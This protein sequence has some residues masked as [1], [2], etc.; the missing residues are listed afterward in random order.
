[1]YIKYIKLPLRPVE[2]LEID[3][4]QSTAIQNKLIKAAFTETSEE[5]EIWRFN[6]GTKS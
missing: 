2:L 5:Y 4:Q 3:F 1:M 6:N